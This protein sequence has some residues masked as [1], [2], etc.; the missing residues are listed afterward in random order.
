MSIS[1]ALNMHKVTK[2]YSGLLCLQVR[3][4]P[5]NGLSRA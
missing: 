4:T 5:A 2:F 1:T 3:R